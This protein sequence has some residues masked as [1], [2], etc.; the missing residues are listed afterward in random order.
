MVLSPTITKIIMF[1]LQFLRAFCP[2]NFIPPV[3]T[4]KF[5]ESMHDVSQFKPPK[6]TLPF[7]YGLICDNVVCDNVVVMNSLIDLYQVESVFQDVNEA[8]D[9]MMEPENYVKTILRERVSI[10]VIYCIVSHIFVITRL[11]KKQRSYLSG[12]G[13]RFC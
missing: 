4:T 5:L 1:C 2:S 3:I 6:S 9:T 8:R 13:E 10:M 11:L 12:D 7:F